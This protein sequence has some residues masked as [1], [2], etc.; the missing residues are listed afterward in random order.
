[1]RSAGTVLVVDDDR[2]ILEAI[3]DELEREGYRV[4]S[5]ANGEEAIAVLD[6]EA[7]DLV[8]LDL[9][10][11]AMSGWHVL[12][13]GLDRD[14]LAAIPVIVISAV[15]RDLVPDGRVR[16]VLRKPFDRSALLDAVANHLAGGRP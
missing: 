16:A 15:P 6:G 7:I 2:D 9:M 13:R 10:M 1:M 12:E 4:V 5:A 14:R 3:R 11:P 8:L